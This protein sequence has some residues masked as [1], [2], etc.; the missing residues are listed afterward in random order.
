MTNYRQSMKDTLEHMHMTTERK[1][2]E[3]EL[4]DQELKRREE[5]AKEM[6]DEDFKDRYGSRWKEVKLAVA[7][8]Q[9]KSESVDEKLTTSVL[10]I[11]SHL[12]SKPARQLINPNKEAMVFHPSKHDVIIIDKSDWRKYEKMGYVQAEELESKIL[13]DKEYAVTFQKGEKV[14]TRSIS[15]IRV[16]AKNDNDA[17]KKASK[18]PRAKGKKMVDIKIDEDFRL[19]EAK[20]SSSKL[21]NY[22]DYTVVAIK[23]GKVVDQLH[24][25]AKNEFKSVINFFKKEN[26]G[27]K[28]SIEDKGGKIIHTEGLE[29][30]PATETDRKRKIRLI[31]LKKQREHD[32]A[33]KF[34][35]KKE[36]VELDLDEAKIKVSIEGLPDIY[37]DGNSPGAV[38]AQLRKVIKN[39]DMIT[40]VERVPVK[41]YKQAMRDRVSGKDD[42]EPEE[43]EE[44]KKTKGTKWE[45][46]DATGVKRIG[47]L[48]KFSDRGGTDVTYFFKRVKDGRLDVVSG[49][50]L[51]NA[52]VVK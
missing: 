33:M 20:Y 46:E 25:V 19:D 21:S 8:K 37:L 44:N 22:P 42:K 3:R 17:Y 30:A 36:E 38:K 15:I 45:Y 47:I 5:I 41:D 43:V 51:K 23:N 1:I 49:S 9:A 31:A 4:T 10:T 26:P 18:D 52:K 14:G 7:T 48:D 2:L 35:K 27:A 16:T 13:E 39:P 24:S 29:T 34:G 6:N 40:S 32:Y 50:R 11:P 12:K 28:I